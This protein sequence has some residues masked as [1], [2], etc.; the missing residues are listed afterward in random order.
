MIQLHDKWIKN[1]NVIKNTHTIHHNTH[2]MEKKASVLIYK[3]IQQESGT[4]LIYRLRPNLH[5]IQKRK[6]QEANRVSCFMC[7]L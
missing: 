4:F 5:F 7:E 6:K 3:Q 2:E 1:K